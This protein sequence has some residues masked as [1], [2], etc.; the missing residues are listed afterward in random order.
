MMC[1]LFG[2]QSKLSKEECKSGIDLARN[3]K[4]RYTL[5]SKNYKLNYLYN[6]CNFYRKYYTCLHHLHNIRLRRDYMLE[7]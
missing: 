2:S 4:K 1:N 5:M 6:F 7:Y 3:L